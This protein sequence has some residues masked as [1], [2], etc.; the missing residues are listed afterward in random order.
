MDATPKPTNDFLQRLKYCAAQCTSAA[1]FARKCG[2]KPNVVQRYYDGSEPTLSKLVMLAKG[3]NV[4]IDWLA[5]GKEVQNEDV[6][7]QK[8]VED[9]K[10]PLSGLIGI[11]EVLLRKDGEREAKSRSLTFVDGAGYLRPDVASN[12]YP[13]ADLA[14]LAICRI[15]DTSLQPQVRPGEYI[16]ID[17]SRRSLFPGV[18]LFRIGETLTVRPMN[19]VESEPGQEPVYEIPS[20]IQPD[21]TKPLRLTESKLGGYIDLWGELVQAGRLGV[22]PGKGRI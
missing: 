12:L 19:I 22:A 17:T 1:A 16:L 18:G 8:G 20:N 11:R 3:A 2:L 10:N 21:G 5:T 14:S 6:Q 9:R 7:A 4:S 13:T 15:N